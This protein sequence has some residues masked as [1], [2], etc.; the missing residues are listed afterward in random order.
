MIYPIAEGSA[1]YSRV[2]LGNGKGD[3][4]L[5]KVSDEMQVCGFT[6]FRTIYVHSLQQD[7]LIIKV[8]DTGH[9]PVLLHCLPSSDKISLEITYSTDMNESG[10]VGDG[11]K[12]KEVFIREI[13]SLEDW[14]RS[15]VCAE[16]ISLKKDEP[17]D[18]T[19][20]IYRSDSNRKN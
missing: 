20:I 7:K 1:L 6:E 19:K 18:P 16:V 17:I 3:P 12:D 5:V 10:A 4:T 2:R 14:Y 8:S 13:V 15:Q 9:D 11:R